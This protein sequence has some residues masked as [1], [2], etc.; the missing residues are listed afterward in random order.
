MTSDG[1]SDLDYL[2]MTCGVT[3]AEAS[4]AIEAL[5]EAFRG[6]GCYSAEFTTGLTFDDRRWV[7]ELADIGFQPPARFAE[8][9]LQRAEDGR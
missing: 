1:G 5:A 8:R 2:A 6:Y 7:H 4:E 3:V 9:W